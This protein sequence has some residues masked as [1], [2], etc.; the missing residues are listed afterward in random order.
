MRAIHLTKSYSGQDRK[1]AEVPKLKYLVV[2]K[3][4]T[5]Y[6]SIRLWPNTLNAIN[7][8]F[9][10]TFLGYEEFHEKVSESTLW[11]FTITVT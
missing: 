6:Q 11:Y 4:E 8:F 5:D 2:Q 1:Y 10:N 9:A 7:W 3:Y